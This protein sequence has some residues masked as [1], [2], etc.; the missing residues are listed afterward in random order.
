MEDTLPARLSSPLKICP[1]L[2]SS[3]APTSS[4]TTAPLS[5][6]QL[7]QRQPLLSLLSLG[8]ALLSV[9]SSQLKLE[10][11][12]PSGSCEV[13]AVADATK[14]IQL[15][16]SMSKA[17]FRKGYQTRGYK[18]RPAFAL[19]ADSSPNTNPNLS[20]NGGDDSPLGTTRLGTLV[21]AAAT[22]LL[23]KLNSA[24]KYFPMKIF[25]LLLGFYT[26]NALATILGQTGDWDVLVAGMVVAAIE[27]IGML[28]Y[29]K[30]VDAKMVGGR[31]QKLVVMVNFWKAG[32]CLGLFVD[33][34]KLGS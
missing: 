12:L 18:W 10:S 3:S 9:L 16:P 4:A 15:D 31:L 19:N 5:R 17:Y 34:F 28:M 22:Q 30:P 27:G 33:A 29:G 8:E 2:L 7:L 20:P 14:A 13:E 25:L 1:T 21:R 6:R 32:V 24:R 11:R 23:N 26:A